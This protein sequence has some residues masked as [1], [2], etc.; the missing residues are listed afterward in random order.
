MSFLSIF[1]VESSD[2]GSGIVSHEIT[3]K[4][5]PI[6][7]KYG[8]KMV[9]HPMCYKMKEGDEYCTAVFFVL[10]IDKWLDIFRRLIGLCSYREWITTQ[11]AEWF[12]RPYDNS[13]SV[14]SISFCPFDMNFMY[15]LTRAVCNSWWCLWKLSDWKILFLFCF[16]HHS[17]QAIKNANWKKYFQLGKWARITNLTKNIRGLYFALAIHPP[18]WRT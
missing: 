18:I 11:K 16:P 6:L 12:S 2:S 10:W 7:G 15:I 9:P 8:R 13:S 14:L 5:V 17:S 1:N 4:D 3:R